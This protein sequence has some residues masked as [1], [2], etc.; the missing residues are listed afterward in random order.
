MSLYD[1]LVATLRSFPKLARYEL[2]CHPS[3]Y[4]AIQAS[5][6]AAQR[7]SPDP[8]PSLYGID[9]IVKPEVGRG[10]WKLYADG[11]LIDYGRLKDTDSF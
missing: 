1:D 3:V 8:M 5:D 6:M 10:V 11:E 2:H 7:Y 4:Y 9:L